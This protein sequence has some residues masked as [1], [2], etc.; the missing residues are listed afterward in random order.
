MNLNHTAAF[1]NAITDNKE[2]SYWAS[3]VEKA[4]SDPAAEK[5]VKM[6][7]YRPAEEFYD[8]IADPYELNNLA[9]DAANRKTMDEMKKQL[10]AWMVQQGDKG[11][12]TEM[13]VKKK[14][15]AGAD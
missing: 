6:Y 2:D 7:Q 10:E 8:I 5:I 15:K 11:M 4:K 12:A 14:A 1:E 3:W 9:G 13:A